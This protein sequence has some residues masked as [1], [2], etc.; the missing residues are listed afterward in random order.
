MRTSAGWFLAAA[1]QHFE[2]SCPSPSALKTVYEKVKKH[3]LV[4]FMNY[5][6]Q[7]LQ[8]FPLRC[9]IRCFYVGNVAVC[10]RL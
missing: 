8:L 5:L 10:K 4:G 6:T 1:D 9:C 7:T 3:V 2:E